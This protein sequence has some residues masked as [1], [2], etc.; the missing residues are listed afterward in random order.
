MFEKCS[1]I[2]F[3]ENSSNGSRVVP[4]E[5]TDGQKKLIVAFHNF[6][7]MSK[8]QYVVVLMVT[9]YSLT[10]QETYKYGQYARGSETSS[11]IEGF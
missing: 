7:N 1:N 4:C 8:N 11:W 6:A 5:R 9:V 10:A 2:K 3:H